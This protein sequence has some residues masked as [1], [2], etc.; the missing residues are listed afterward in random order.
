MKLRTWLRPGMFIKRWVIMLFGGLVL[1]SLALAMGLAWLYRNY[2]FPTELAGIVRI[3]TLQFIPHPYREIGLL[4]V[5]AAWVFFSFYE[6]SRSLLAPFLAQRAD[7]Q[8][9][10]DIIQR[11]RF[12]PSAPELR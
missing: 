1:T 3:V 5:G 10:V 12:G 11:H 9:L 4:I 2:H 7:G 6:L 8:G